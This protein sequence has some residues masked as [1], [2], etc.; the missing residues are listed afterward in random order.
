MRNI[1]KIFAKT[2]RVDFPGTIVYNE[3]KTKRRD[4]NEMRI[5]RQRKHGRRG[6]TFCR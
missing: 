3:T 4:S 5:Y 2:V 6:C 1:L